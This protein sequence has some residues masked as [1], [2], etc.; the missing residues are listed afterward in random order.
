M[1]ELPSVTEP[2]AISLVQTHPFDPPAELRNRQPIRRIR[3]SDGEIGWLVTSH[4]LAKVVLTD[5]RFGRDRPG[6]RFHG[7]FGDPGWM[8]KFSD[9]CE[10]VGYRPMR[11]FIEMNPPDHTRIRRLLASQFTIRRIAAFRPRIE[12]IVAEHLDALAQTDQP[13]DL[14]SAFTT[15]V[16]L[17]SQ[18]AL[19]GIP[20][21]DARRFFRLGT[22][23]SDP[24]LTPMEVANAWREAYD[25]VR[26]VAVEKRLHPTDD[27]ISFVASHAELTDDEVA[28]TALVL[29]Q[30]GLETTG[31]MMALGA[32]A[33]LCHPDQLNALRQDSSRIESAVEELLRYSGIFR[34]LPRT[35][36]EDM[37]LDGNLV[38]TGELVTVSP[39]AAN[40]D[41]RKFDDPDDLRLERS[42][43]GHVPFAQGIHMCLGQ[44]L[45]RLELQ[46][47]LRGLIQRFPALRLAVAADHVPVYGAI[48]PIYGVYMLPIAWSLPSENPTFEIA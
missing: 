29:F 41:P 18:C 9:A 36:L 39:A 31:D 44:H 19:L 20:Y 21:T 48:Q 13:A 2:I 1:T 3:Y 11:G 27:V 42:A 28:D 8:A 34:L 24:S 7:G 14:V 43:T 16:S 22:S 5:S 37:D 4:A 15:Q 30:G 40:R 33:L 6:T 45:A 47:G 10:A 26:D 32:F 38:K 17:S 23:G 12:Q 35:A 46:I 25:F